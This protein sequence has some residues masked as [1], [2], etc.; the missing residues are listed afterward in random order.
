MIILG[1]DHAG[2]EL[3]EILKQYLINKNE[4]V[5]DVGANALDKDD[6]FSTFVKL[7]AEVF[8][9]NKEAKI[10]AVC[11]SGV[12]MNIGLNKN[13]NIFCCLGHTPEEVAKAREHNN[14]NALA[15]GGRTTK[16]EDAK[17]MVEAFLTTPHIGGKYTQRMMDI[18]LK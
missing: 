14:I 7:M 10:I 16:V 8:Y 13:K 1:A 3:K 12:G 11:G 5:L 4:E 18:D 6:N 17:Q 9:K 15:L 2:L